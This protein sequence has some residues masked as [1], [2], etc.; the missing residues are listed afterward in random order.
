[1]M[2][3]ILLFF[4]VVLGI[5]V[6]LAKSRGLTRISLLV[7]PAV[8][9]AAVICQLSGV[10]WIILPGWLQIYFSF[11]PIGTFFLTIMSVIFMV[12]AIYSLFYFNEHKFSAQQEA[13][14]TVIIFLFVASMTG[15]LLATHL[16][17]LWV[18]VEA[19]TLSSALLIYFERK[20]SS[21]EAAWKYVYICSIGIALA[22]IGIIL[23][24][25]GSRSFDSL[26][27]ND[28]YKHALEINPFWLQIAFAFIFIGFGT[29]IGIAPIHAWLP[30]AHS[31]AP[32]PVSALLSGTLLNS[33]FLGLIRVQKIM[34][35]AHEEY[36]SNFLLLVTGFFSLLIS[37]V[38]MLQIKNYKR[39]LA[40][41]SIENMGILFI[42]VALGEPGIFA[43]MLHTVAHSFSKASLFL[44]S[45]N[46][47][48]LYQTKKSDEVRGLIKKDPV[49]GWIWITSLLSISGLP[50]FPSFISKFLIIKAFFIVNL[51]WLAIPFFIL[52]AII[53]YGMGGTVFKMSFGNVQSG[54]P[55]KRLSITAYIGQEILLVLLL[56][57]G[58]NIPQS[59]LS[60]IQRAAGFF[61]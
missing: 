47:L 24:S 44:T 56:T 26:F 25:I 36:F 34:I 10:N 7:V 5:I 48:N 11:D 61:N 28:L 23:L 43:A 57:I 30:D 19:T 55:A 3:S 38:F 20:K 22:F 37:A 6:L 27:F 2:I 54:E 33:A 46:I 59:V 16:A 1:M 32:S 21:L 49:T 13:A 40:Y 17:L 14:Y 31:E 39:M 8:Y 51:G 35:S 18:F 41:S 9:L 12:S 58:T 29:K 60:F 15:V 42:G 52:L 4:P 50:P 45:G 53:M